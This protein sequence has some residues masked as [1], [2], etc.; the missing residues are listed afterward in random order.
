MRTEPESLKPCIINLQMNF[1]D[2]SLKN[3]RDEKFIHLL[4]TIF[5]V[6]I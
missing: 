5:G 6:Q 1:I 4:E 3:L 2:R